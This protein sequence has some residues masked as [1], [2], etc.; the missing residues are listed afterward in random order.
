MCPWNASVFLLTATFCG[1]ATLNEWQKQ[2]NNQNNV[3]YNKTNLVG[4]TDAE[5]RQMLGNPNE[6][7]TF[8]STLGR[9]DFYTYRQLSPSS[10]V[11]IRLILTNGVVTNISYD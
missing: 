9:T 2:W 4:M 10:P 5:L 1:C 6:V 8:Y 11:I 3:Y 7:N